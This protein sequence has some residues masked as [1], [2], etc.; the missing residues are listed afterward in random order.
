MWILGRTDGSAHAVK[1]QIGYEPSPEDINLE[2][3]DLSEETVASM[4]EVDPAL[5]REDIASIKEFYARFGDKLP[6][7]MK[8]QLTALE[9]RLD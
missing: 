8:K 1:S 7:E 2:G 9:A 5:W 3:L 6:K 4:L